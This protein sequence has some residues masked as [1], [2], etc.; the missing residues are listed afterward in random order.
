M[1]KLVEQSH[2]EAVIRWNAKIISARL[3]VLADAILY[4][5]L[6]ERFHME[7]RSAR[8]KNARSPDNPVGNF[9]L[10]HF[11]RI[12]RVLRRNRCT[13]DLMADRQRRLP[14]LPALRSY[15]SLKSAALR[16]RRA[17]R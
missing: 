12:A 2:A 3:R 9:C 16:R 5:Q 14:L 1:Q 11:S 13:R 8:W 15:L 4:H 6:P 10:Y 7:S 17:L